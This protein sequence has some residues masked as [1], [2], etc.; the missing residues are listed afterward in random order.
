MARALDREEGC[1]RNLRGT[2]QDWHHH[3]LG[4]GS[5]FTAMLAEYNGEISGMLIYGV[6]QLPGW[7]APVLKVHDLYVVP[8]RR[9]R[10]VART[11]M[12]HVTHFAVARKIIMTH[13][14]VRE[15]NPARHFYSQ[16]GFQH[17]A[18]CLTYLM[19]LP[20]LEQLEKIATEF[21]NPA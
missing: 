20:A 14:N 16:A 9:R 7:S 6:E 5:R 1:I 8:A 19:A 10:H 3:L 12:A 2:L 21:A 15:D 11:L 13:L 18:Q 17:V 4:A